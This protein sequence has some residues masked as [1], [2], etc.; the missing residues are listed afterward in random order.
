MVAALVAIDEAVDLDYIL[1]VD[2]TT[3]R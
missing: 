1:A 2:Q 3:D